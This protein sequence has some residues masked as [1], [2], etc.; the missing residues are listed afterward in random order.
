MIPPKP[1]KATRTTN[2]VPIR[3][4]PPSPGINKS[5]HIKTAPTVSFSMPLTLGRAQSHGFRA[6]PS[7]A[8]TDSPTRATETESPRMSPSSSTARTSAAS[9]N[10]I[11][12][13][14]RQ[15]AKTPASTLVT[16]PVSNDLQNL[17]LQH[18]CAA[19]SVPGMRNHAVALLSKQKRKA[20]TKGNGRLDHI[21]QY[22]KGRVLRST[23][24]WSPPSNM[25]RLA[26]RSPDVVASCPTALAE[27]PADMGAGS[28]VC[29]GA[30]RQPLAELNVPTT[31]SNVI[32]ACGTGN[33]FPRF[34][35]V[36]RLPGCQLAHRQR[37]F[38]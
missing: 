27:P 11:S 32:N 18:S 19:A 36:T 34:T 5:K 12:D 9:G 24:G 14:K 28:G 33:C 20:G 22:R 38:V 23:P 1:R 16:A 6:N 17:V 30:A 8:A 3:G 35:I 26:G 37:S 31:A 2:R 25:K 13:R 29:A 21:R 4:N 15:R 10:P 7:L